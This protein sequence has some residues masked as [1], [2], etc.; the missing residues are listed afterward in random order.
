MLSL[1]SCR[2]VL[3]TISFTPIY[4]HN[5]FMW[6]ERQHLHNSLPCGNIGSKVSQLPCAIIGSKVSQWKT[7]NC[8]CATDASQITYGCKLEKWVQIASVLDDFCGTQPR[9]FNQTVASIRCC[10]CLTNEHAT[11]LIEYR[12]SA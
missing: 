2:P 9:H 11:A 12:Q 5:V 8:I 6:V 1:H 10:N 4:S 3:L 7:C